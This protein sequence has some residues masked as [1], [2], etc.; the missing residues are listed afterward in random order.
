MV[1]EKGVI[2]VIGIV[3]NEIVVIIYYVD[4]VVVIDKIGFNDKI[5]VDSED[6]VEI[7]I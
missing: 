6:E 5:K 4:L 3:V 2:D 1:L 7:W